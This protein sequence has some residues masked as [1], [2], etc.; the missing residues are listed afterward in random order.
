MA[1]QK[2]MKS[3]IVDDSTKRN[4][5]VVVKKVYAR[6]RYK[7]VDGHSDIIEESSTDRR[8]EDEVLNTSKRARL[9]D[10][11]R[12]LVRNS[13]LFNTILG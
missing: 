12:N 5:K 11:T 4:A 9:L 13:S 1:R 3:E 2:K 8:K 7:I 6:G 10:L